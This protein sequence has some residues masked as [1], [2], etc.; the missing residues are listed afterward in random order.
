MQRSR[1]RAF[2]AQQQITSGKRVERPSD[3]PTAYGQMVRDEAKLAAIEQALRNVQVGMSRIQAADSLLDQVTM[4]LSRIKELAVGASS[5]TMTAA[6]R[7]TIAQ[8]VRQLH[9]HLV[10]LANSEFG[11]YRLFAGTRTDQAPFVLGP[12]E[13]V[14]YQGNSETLAIAV[15]PNQTIPVLLPGNH[16]FTGPTTNVFDTVANLL[17]ALESNNQAG[18]EQSLTNLDQALDQVTRA[19]G[20]LGALGNRLETTTAE[21]EQRKAIVTVALSQMQDADLVQAASDLARHE[22]ALQAAAQIAARLFDTSLVRFLR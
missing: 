7:A 22:L 18:I 15:G 21:L 12:N 4:V 8:E 17:A 9:R 3:D 10:Q 16:V 2:V 1:E 11:G 13:A 5:G 20:Q 19:R 6:N 14:S